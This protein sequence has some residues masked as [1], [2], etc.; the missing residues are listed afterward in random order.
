MADR[1][2]DIR[3]R[4]ATACRVLGSLEL[5]KAATGHVSA[6][7]VGGILI[8]ARGPDEL[9]VRYTTPDQ[10]IAC[11]L[12]GCSIDDRP[13]LSAPQEV[14]I[15][16]ALY[17]ARPEVQAVVHIHPQTPVLF[18]VCDAPLLPIYGAYDPASAGIALDGVPVYP[19]SILISTPSL[20]NDLATAMG[21]APVCLM[22][23]HGIT[24]VGYSIEDAALN[25][26][27]LNEFAVMN[28]QARLLGNPQPISAEDQEA[29]D[30]FRPSRG[31]DATAAAAAR[32]VALWRYYVALTG[33]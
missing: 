7:T 5:T 23:G 20:G 13:G 17:K 31:G 11:D 2:D 21:R 27:R 22:R 3:L 16:T 4:I 25:A 8:R 6:R 19:R 32:A 9:G 12:D 15:H 24:T 29:F 30:E 33:A 28:Y 26:I 18:T 1:D 14:F 10:V